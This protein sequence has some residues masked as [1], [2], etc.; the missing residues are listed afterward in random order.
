MRKPLDGGAV[1]SVRTSCGVPQLERRS[2]RL[3]TRTIRWAITH[4]FKLWPTFGRNPGTAFRAYLVRSTRRQDFV[5][6]CHDVV[7]ELSNL[8]VVEKFVPRLHG[9]IRTA[10]SNPIKKVF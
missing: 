6:S 2:D 7:I 4:L 10:A 8:F 3:I 5:G 1:T 9:A